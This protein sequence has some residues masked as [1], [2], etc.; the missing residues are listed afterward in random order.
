VTKLVLR[1][2]TVLALS[3]SPL[4]LA[5]EPAPADVPLFSQAE[6]DQMLAPVALYPDELLSQ[7]LMA[8]TY[9]LEVVEAARFSRAR[10]ELKGQDAVRAAEKQSWDP[11]VKAMLAFPQILSRMDEDLEWTRRLGDAFLAQQE[12]VMET[13]Q[14]LRKRADEAG[15]LKETEHVRV[16]RE[17]RTIIVR[18]RYPDV[19]Y[20]PYYDPVMIYGSWWWPDYQ[21]VRW[22]PW[23]GYRY[24]SGYSGFFWGPS[25]VVGHGFFFS[26]YD[27][28]DRYVRI[29]E[30]PPFYYRHPP[31][32]RYRWKHEYQHRKGVP[33]PNQRV[34]D[35]YR[36][37]RD[38]VPR[39]QP[40]DYPEGAPRYAP[41]PAAGAQVPVVPVVPGT[42]PGPPRGEREG[43]AVEAGHG[44]RDDSQAPRGRP[45]TDAGVA[46]PPAPGQPPPQPVSGIT[47]TPP[48]P[49]VGTAPSDS[50]QGRP[51]NP[52]RPDGT[53]PGAYGPDREDRGDRP[54]ESPAR[55]AARQEEQGEVAAPRTET[56]AYRPPVR[57]TPTYSTPRQEQ[58][59]YTPPPPRDTSPPPRETPSYSAPREERPSYTPPPPRETPSYNVPREERPS[60]TPPPPREA[61]SYSAPRQTQPSYTPAPPRETPSYS[62]PRQAQ[63]SYTP[64]P[65]RETPSYN[66]PREERP[67]YTPPPPREAPSYSAPRQTQ[68]SYTPP[69][70]R[71]TPS[72]SAPRQQQ[73]SYTPPP[74]RETPSYSAP[75]S[76]PAPKGSD[77]PRGRGNRERPDERA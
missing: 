33:Y 29:V 4:A 19:V 55:S 58:Q 17:E 34:Y 21:P 74:P 42:E 15:N 53:A 49:A 10:P 46:T 32:P 25:I 6:L 28:R 41:P 63:P 39:R 54:R 60:Y 24:Y 14:A 69:P 27:W 71:E 26:H 11:S 18:N 76:E 37:E 65:P 3:F 7:L 40:R 62:A 50:D 45:E 1:L 66:A 38:P 16:V 22:S 64:P 47:V 57:E 68:P 8:A 72:Y 30:A 36:D 67:S 59:G 70:P 20:V 5:E 51:A 48:A 35:R 52:Q 75:R 56:P 73:P 12:Q 13:V 9:P 2:L 23:T 31:P 61:P 77:E 44:K 43:D